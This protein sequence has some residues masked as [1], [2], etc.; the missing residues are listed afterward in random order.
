VINLGLTDL[1]ALVALALS[2][3]NFVFG[4]FSWIVDI[5]RGRTEERLEFIREVWGGFSAHNW[6][7]IE[8]WD[9]P[10]VYPPLKEIKIPAKTEKEKEAFGL[11]VVT[12]EH[13]NILLK[14]FTHRKILTKEDIQGFTSWGKCWYDASL[15]ALKVIF[16]QGDIF[17]LDYTIW[18]RD[19]VFDGKPFREI[20]GDELKA[21]LK[22]YEVKNELPFRRR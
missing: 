15:P 8:Y 19:V 10:G 4:A 16:S 7:F 21:R 13:L 18:L 20:V 6:S 17:P 5:R 12:L 2:I 14:V 3:F 11:R 1:V 22:R 9:F